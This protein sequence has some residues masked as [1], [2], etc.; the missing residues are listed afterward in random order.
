MR[1]VNEVFRRNQRHSGSGLAVCDFGVNGSRDPH[2]RLGPYFESPPRSI[3]L[4]AAWFN[5][6]V[7]YR[8]ESFGVGELVCELD[9]SKGEVDVVFSW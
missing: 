7:D 6:L 9:A 1:E 4:P 2:R 5:F 3:L 8:V